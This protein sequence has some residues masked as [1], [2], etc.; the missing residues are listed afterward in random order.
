M[1]GRYELKY[2]RYESRDSIRD[3]SL[4]PPLIRERT[5]S[6]KRSRDCYE[7]NRTDGS[8]IYKQVLLDL[9]RE[10]QDKPPRNVYYDTESS[11]I[12]HPPLPSP[13]R[14]EYLRH[15]PLPTRSE[16]LRHEPLPP[17]SEYLRDTST[18]SVYERD[19][20]M[21]PPRSVCTHDLQMPSASQSD[22]M[23][24]SSYHARNKRDQPSYFIDRN[25]QYDDKYH[26]PCVFGLQGHCVHGNKCKFLHPP[27]LGGDSRL[28]NKKWD[29][30]KWKSQFITQ[31]HNKLYNKK[32]LKRS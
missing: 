22:N 6:L 26:S 18:R 27:S 14:S 23:H 13:P 30:V 28:W 7:N 10:S 4:S 1:R 2:N 5:T 31:C 3:H 29:N 24:R 9:I 32:K 17:R 11:Y 25:P 16:Y 8:D 21:P 15:E 19:R 12:R 20:Q